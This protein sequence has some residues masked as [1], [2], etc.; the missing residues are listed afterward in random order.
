MFLPFKFLT[1]FGL[2]FFFGQPVQWYL[3]SNRFFP[4]RGAGPVSLSGAPDK[5]IYGVQTSPLP[6]PEVIVAEW[7]TGTTAGT[8]PLGRAWPQSTQIYKLCY[9]EPSPPI[10]HRA[11]AQPLLSCPR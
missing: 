3:C 2:V 9:H 5:H 8:A 6:A 10:L 1:G 4:Q 7:G 11:P